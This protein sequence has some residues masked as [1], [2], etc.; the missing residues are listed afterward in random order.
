M[1]DQRYLVYVD[2]PNDHYTTVGRALE[3]AQELALADEGTTYLVRKATVYDVSEV[4]TAPVTTVTRGLLNGLWGYWDC[5]DAS[6]TTLTDVHASNDLSISVTWNTDADAV[7]GTSRAPYDVGQTASAT[8]PENVRFGFSFS[9]WFKAGGGNSAG[10]LLS[11]TDGT[12]TYR[13]DVNDYGGPDYVDIEVYGAVNSS[14]QAYL[15]GADTYTHYAFTWDGS[16]LRAYKNAGSPVLH[17]PGSY[18][19]D[20]VT[21]ALG[22]VEGGVTDEWGFW[23]RALT[24]S[25][26]SDLYNDGSGLA[27]GSF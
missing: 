18:L 25:E 1:A 2:E 9:G 26:I 17:S 11:V 19:G 6:S 24:A 15:F 7:L 22:S 8:G 12:T 27:Y 23:T 13:L 16:L 21:I 10:L 5:D 14:A 4:E 20:T 3:A